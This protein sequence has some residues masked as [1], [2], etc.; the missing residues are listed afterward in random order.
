MVLFVDSAGRLWIGTND[1]GLCCYDSAS[2]ET[3]FYTTKDGLDAD[4]IRAVCE[5]ENGN[6]YVGT[7]GA[8]SVISFSDGTAS[9]K[10]YD[11]N[12]DII[13]VRSLTS[14]SGDLVAG[15]TNSGIF[16]LLKDGELLDTATSGEDGVYYLSVSKGSDAELLVGTSA[17]SMIRINIENRRIEPVSSV[18]TGKTTYINEIYY[19]PQSCGFFYCAENGLG[20][21]PDGSDE[22]TDLS[23]DSFNSSVSGVICDYENNIWFVSNKQGILELSRNPFMNVFAR[24]GLEETVVNA[25]ALRDGV[26]Y[27]GTDSG[28]Y[29]ID[30]STFK[31]KHFDFLS[32]FKGVRIR[33]ILNDS[34]NNLWISTYGMDGLVKVDAKGNC[35]VYNESTGTVGG[36]FRYCLEVSDGTIYAASNMGINL[37]RE[38]K[39]EGIIGE[40][41]GLTAQIL[42]MVEDED[43]TIY[44]GSDG[45][46]IYVLRDEKLVDTIGASDGLETL[47]VMRIVPCPDGYL[48]V[49]S[50]ALYFDNGSEM[51]SP[52]VHQFIVNEDGWPCMLPYQTQGETVSK[53]GYSKEEIAGR[54][55]FIDQGT[56]INAEIAE[57]E[58]LYL[59]ENGTAVTESTSGTWKMKDGTCYM[60][61][62]LGDRIYKG[63]FCAM[64]DEAGTPVMTF[65]AV[66]YNESV[67][68]VKY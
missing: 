38:G 26:I 21:L 25:V 29:A 36:R 14:Y 18:D 30:S 13:G 60:T 33:H 37:I 17:S 32:V 27:F 10:T 56:A 53:T 2:N 7:V 65:S 5:D 11:D 59:N 62:S 57:P 6:I 58:I 46:G 54:Y 39:L 45:E 41:D 12:S 44:A 28:L 47:V 50:N 66:G 40:D 35:T 9:L 42:T 63:V 4:S 61:L 20:F 22:V 67:W 19:D 24:A 31:Q 15:V 43:G 34:D 55:Y 51:H 3:S 23:N 16:F 52:R 64:D 68:G 49:T 8:M 48:Y 1:S